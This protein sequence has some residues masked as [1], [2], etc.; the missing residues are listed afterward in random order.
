MLRLARLRGAGLPGAGLLNPR[1]DGPLIEGELSTTGRGRPWAGSAT[2]SAVGE[3]E[4]GTG[5]ASDALGRG[6]ESS[7]APHMPQKRFPSEFSL[8]HRGQRTDISSPIAY[9]ILQVRCRV[10][11]A[12]FGT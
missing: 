3:A 2:T 9:D 10:V 8:P 12:Q 4:T 7:D 11:V 5:G 1:N 6:A